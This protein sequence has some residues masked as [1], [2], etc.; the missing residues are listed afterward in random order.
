MPYILQ[1]KRDEFD[2]ILDELRGEIVTAGQLGYVVA[3]V[4]DF[5]LLKK[6][7]DDTTGNLRYSYMGE[8]FGILESIKLDFFHEVNEPYE[9]DVRSRA[10]EVWESAQR[11][12]GRNGNAV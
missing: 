9:N 3:K 11:L 12:P 5:W 8:V 1:D 10:G 4:I 7:D 6:A 2:K